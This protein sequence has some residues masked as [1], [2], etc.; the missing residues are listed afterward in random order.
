MTGTKQLS[1]KII[2]FQH[3]RSDPAG[4][5]LPVSTQPLLETIRALDPDAVSIIP[6][7]RNGYYLAKRVLDV[8]LSVLLL[9]FLLPV[10]LIIAGVVYLSSPG[11]VIFIQERVGVKRRYY[12]DHPYWK[13]TNYQNYKFRTMKTNADQSIHQAYMKALIE[14]NEDEMAAL[15]GKDTQSRKLVNDSRVTSA[16]KFL[17][18]FS[19]DELPQILNVLRGE[20]SLVGPRPAIPYEVDMYHPW[21]YRRLESLPG[22]TGLQQVKARSTDFDRQV[23]LDIEYIEKQS[24]WLD[25]KIIFNTIWAVLSTKGAY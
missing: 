25:I 17:R 15:Q 19:L 24:F 23:C 2:P 8:A 4:G 12:E 9:P 13:K 16:G 5:S 6:T 20:M 10:M 21:H 1:D 3:S 7:E 22:V 11:P 18:K 14:K